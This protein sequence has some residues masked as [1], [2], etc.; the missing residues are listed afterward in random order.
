MLAWLKRLFERSS[1]EARAAQVYAAAEGSEFERCAITGLMTALEASEVARHCRAVK[2]EHQVNFMMA[3]ACL[4][5]W[6]IR[7][8]MEGVVAAQVA[9]SALRAMQRHLAKPGCYHPGALEKIWGE[10][11][12]HLPWAMTQQPGGPPPYPVAD[13]LIAAKWAGYDVEPQSQEF[14]DIKFG[15]YVAVMMREIGEATRLAARDLC[16][17]PV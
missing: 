12:A 10:I 14:F 11:D 5:M 7:R 2:S 4:M 17:T 15:I 6:A 16:K 13:M 8:G 3:Y 1:P 9:D